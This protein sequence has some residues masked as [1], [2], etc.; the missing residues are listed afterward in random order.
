MR[1]NHILETAA[2]VF[3]SVQSISLTGVHARRLEITGVDP[4]NYV[5]KQVTPEIASGGIQQLYDQGVLRFESE[6]ESTKAGK[7]NRRKMIGGGLRS[8][9]SGAS[10]Q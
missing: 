6:I 4:E 5:S 2:A 3:L 8:R 1:S 7:P 10:Q 9:S